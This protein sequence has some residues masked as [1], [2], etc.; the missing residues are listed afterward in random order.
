MHRRQSVV[1]DLEPPGPSDPSQPAFHH[2]ANRPQ[3]AAV[4]R[5]RSRQ[6]I[7][8][9]PCLQALPVPLGPIG[10]VPVQS[11]RLA[12]GPPPPPVDGRDIV[13]Q[14]ERL[15]GVGAVRSG[16]PHG[17]RGAVAIDE[18]VAFGAFFSPLGGV[19]AGEDPPK[20]ARIDWLS[21][22]AL[23]QSIRP[24]R[25]KRSSSAC[26]S[27]FQTPRRCQYR[28]RRQQVTPEPQPISQGRSSQGRPVLRTKT[29]P[30]RQARSST[31][32]RPRLPG[33]ALCR[34]SS[35]W[36][37][38]HSPSGTKGPGIAA[39]PISNAGYWYCTGL[40]LKWFL[41]PPALAPAWSS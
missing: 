19:F 33:L 2:V 40:F 31:G 24:S 11:L 35:G 32:G 7:L 4:G 41:R 27:L 30:V 10:S 1:P 3:A 13:E 20:T 15:G 26:S 34:G 5:P 29:M 17:Q 14:G 12:A 6:V 8:D 21:T 39:S 9:P 18:Q 25:P 37:V 38:S 28:R 16:E 36:I 23:S 22:Q